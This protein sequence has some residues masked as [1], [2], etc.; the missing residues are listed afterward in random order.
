MP[1]RDQAMRSGSDLES[2]ITDI[3]ANLGLEA[4]RQVKVGK[5]I[6]GAE[7][8]IDVVLRNLETRQTLG[9]ECKA[10]STGGTA[11]EKIPTTIQDIQAWPIPGIVV[12]AGEGF[13]HN[14]RSYLYSTGKA[15]DLEDLEMWLRLFF[16][17]DY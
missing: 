13:S 4:R 11:E 16:G 10:Q 6:W 12:I 8:R 3:A 2:A 7:R 14:M 15:V 9:I 17:L 1:G 5:R